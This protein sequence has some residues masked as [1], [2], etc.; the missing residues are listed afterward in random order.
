MPVKN[1]PAGPSKPEFIEPTDHTPEEPKPVDNSNAAT[2]VPR[3]G[4]APTTTTKPDRPDRPEDKE[5][6]K[7][8]SYV[9]LA[10]G[11]V[12]RCNNEDLPA[13][14][15]ADFGHWNESGKVHTIVAV[16]PVEETVKG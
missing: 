16:Y 8:Q 10:N 2:E 14:G 11:T 9:W 12:K 15:G 13:T 6:D 4:A 5:E 1:P 7:P 3:D